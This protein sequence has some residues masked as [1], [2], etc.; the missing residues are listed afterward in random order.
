[1]ITASPAFLSEIYV[2]RGRELGEFP[3]RSSE[4]A[5]ILESDFEKLGEIL[6]ERIV[7]AAEDGSLSNAPHFYNIIRVWKYLDSWVAPKNWLEAGIGHCVE[8]MLKSIR[9]MVSYSIGTKNREYSWQGILDEQ[10]YDAELLVSAGT[11]FL[12]T[13]SL[14]TDER[15]LLTEVVRGALKVRDQAVTK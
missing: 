11:R 8:F 10:I 9:P 13:S 3:S 7:A 6:L 4:A 12:E 14:S 2:D 15:N 1:M 5:T